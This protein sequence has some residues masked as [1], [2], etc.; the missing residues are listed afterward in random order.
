MKTFK[1]YLTEKQIKNTDKK[2]GSLLSEISSQYHKSYNENVEA[3][4]NQLMKVG[5]VNVEHVLLPESEKK[6]IDF[7]P[8][9]VELRKN[10]NAAF[11]V[12]MKKDVPDFIS[13]LESDIEIMKSEING[14]LLKLKIPNKELKPEDL[15][16]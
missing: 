16:F 14:I 6:I 4:K 7:I 9:K 2:I 11:V 12:I 1:D 10:L 5:T 15:P 8:A 3:I 13:N